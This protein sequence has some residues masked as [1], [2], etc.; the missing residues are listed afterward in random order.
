MSKSRN[1][2]MRDLS[3]ILN[4]LTGSDINLDSVRDADLE[5]IKDAISFLTDT[6]RFL[7]EQAEFEKDEL[8]RVFSQASQLYNEIVG[9]LA[10]I[11]DDNSYTYGDL[12]SRTYQSIESNKARKEIAGD[13]MNRLAK[14]ICQRA[15]LKVQLKLGNA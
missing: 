1:E 7:I 4:E 15:H 11:E 10:N 5:P 2:K 9:A 8:V 3:S 14:G 6:D 12:S 13:S